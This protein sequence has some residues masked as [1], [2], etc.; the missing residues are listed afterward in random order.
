MQ[1]LHA[2]DSDGVSPNGV[3][4]SSDDERAAQIVASNS[5][6]EGA[7]DALLIT[8]REL[9]CVRANQ[10]AAQLLGRPAGEL[11]GMLAT[12]VVAPESLRDLEAGWAAAL[13]HGGGTGA[14]TIL[15]PCG[16]RRRTEYSG[17][18]EIIP[19][20]HLIALRDVSERVEME[21]ELQRTMTAVIAAERRYSGLIEALPEGI[22][23]ADAAGRITL[24]NSRTE[25]MFG[26]VRD[27]LIGRP[28]ELLVPVGPR[29]EHERSRRA[30]NGDALQAAMRHDANVRGRRKDGSEFRAD[31]SLSSV[32]GDDGRLVT[33]VI[34][35]ITERVQLEKQLQL[36]QKLEAV[37]SLAGGV[38]HDFNNILQVIA[39]YTSSMQQRVETDEER[40]G[41]S[42]IAVA[43]E[44]AASLT[45]QLL[46]FSRRQVVQ[47]VV[48]DLNEIVEE[49]E[50]MLARMVGDNIELLTNLDP[51]LKPIRAD[52]AQLEQVLANLVVNARDAITDGGRITISTKDVDLEGLNVRLSIE[53][54]GR[55]ID[56]ET[57]ARAFE[58]FFTTKAPG[59]GN[60][61]G[62]AT[63][64]GIVTQGGGT[65][66]IERAQ[67]G[68]TVVVACI[69]AV[70]EQVMPNAGP[71]VAAPVAGGSERVLLVEDEPVVR[72]LICSLLEGFGY[73]VTAA[74][75]GGNALEAAAG[76]APFDLLITDYLLPGMDGS[77]V[78][79]ALR[80]SGAVSP[81][82]FISGYAPDTELGDAQ[83]QG[84]T[85]YLQKPFARDALA[86]Q[87]RSLLDAAGGR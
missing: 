25:Q 59:G 28:L 14:L 46:A 66:H 18:P 87:V 39:G 64:H 10:A 2:P 67:G 17:T 85:A 79:A 78:A 81:V 32:E 74:S 13:E 33:A 60:G 51:S 52:R 75:S 48:V 7:R 6:F 23:A 53:D 44:R 57:A 12:E 50:R 20:F 58:P 80:A 62:L 22:V 41:L 45:R 24:V 1:P 27:E 55:G 38:A 54:N 11:V 71:D 84:P 63:V 49:T 16:V 35:D 37:G 5:I 19:G 68:G 15:K 76:V 61:L 77:A 29:K 43:V 69:P 30:F 3:A 8:D 56:D 42:E 34:T 21:E 4:G 65:V 83:A 70:S 86:H 9:R 26:Y 72:R 73:R 82:L 40:L 31:I 36:A 47:P